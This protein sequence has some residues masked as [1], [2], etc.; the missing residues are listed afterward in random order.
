MEID[1]YRVY[2][3]KVI[4]QYQLVEYHLEGLFAIMLSDG[5]NFLE[6]AKRVEN[7]AMG[8]LIRKVKFLVKQ[9][10]YSNII[11]KNDINLLYK[12]RDDRNYYCHENYLKM[13][14]AEK[15]NEPEERTKES[16]KNDLKM[17]E[18]LNNK[19]RSAFEQIKKSNK[20]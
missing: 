12:I 16:I 20:K 9:Y 4:E 8:E 15:H 1:E 6:L 7:D 19:L 11:T 17:C 10:N 13:R 3:S 5:D 2:H 14:Y 18:E